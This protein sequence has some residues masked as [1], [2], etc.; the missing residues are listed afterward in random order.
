MCVAN[1]GK[2]GIQPL[3]LHDRRG[4]LQYAL[5]AAAAE[6]FEQLRTHQRF[7]VAARADQ[8]AVVRHENRSG[9]ARHG[10]AHCVLQCFCARQSIPRHGHAA[11]LLPLLAGKA[12]GLVSAQA[13]R[14]GVGL[15]RVNDKIDVLKH[16]IGERVHRPFAG[17]PA[18]A[19]PFAGRQIA[20]RD[21]LRRDAAVVHA[22]GRDE[23][24]FAVRAGRN[25]APRPG[26]KP[27]FQQLAAR[28]TDTRP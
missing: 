25:I 12:A 7:V 5:P 28:F 24:M 4:F 19:G 26:D 18:R 6:P 21:I 3:L 8:N 1:L 23:I 27:V 13:Q 22:A 16:R 14:R 2:H 10:L 20:Q 17:R 15:V 11:E 9:P